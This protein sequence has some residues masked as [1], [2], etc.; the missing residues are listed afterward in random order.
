MQP[1]WRVAGVKKNFDTDEARHPGERPSMPRNCPRIRFGPGFGKLQVAAIQEKRMMTP[2]QLGTERRSLGSSQGL[3]TALVCSPNWPRKRRP[4]Q[5]LISF[6]SS[7]AFHSTNSKAV[8]KVGAVI[9]TRV[10]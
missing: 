5:T 4:I 8:E 6:R 1:Q 2:S 10:S 3:W 7:I 9:Q